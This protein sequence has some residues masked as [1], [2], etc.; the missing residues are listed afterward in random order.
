MAGNAAAVLQ[1]HHRRLLVIQSAVGT[2]MGTTWDRLANVDQPSAERFTKAAATL[3]TA[4]VAATAALSRSMYDVLAPEIDGDIAPVVIRGG[5]PPAELYQRSIITS[6]SLLAAGATWAAAMAAGRARAVSAARTDVMLANRAAAQAQ[7]DARP[8]VEGFTRLLDPGACEYCASLADE[9]YSSADAVPLHNNCVIGS[10]RVD[11]LDLREVSRRRYAGEVVVLRTAAGHELAITPNHPV[12]T[13][14]GWVAAG[15]LREGMDVIGRTAGDRVG[16]GVPH[17]HDV[18]ARIEDRFRAGLMSRLARMPFAT[19]HFH[20]D[21]GQGEVDVVPAHRHLGHGLFAKLDQPAEELALTF[22][23]LATPLPRASGALQDVLVLATTTHRGVRR[24]DLSEPLLRCHRCGH[25]R[26]RFSQTTRRDARPHKA[27]TD[28]R[29]RDAGF[30][31]DLQ[32]GGAGNVAPD[33]IV[34]LRRVGGLHD[35]FNLHTGNGWYWAESIAVHNCGCSV[36]PIIGRSDPARALNGKLL[37]SLKPGS[38]DV[39][40]HEHGEMGAVITDAA[41][42]FST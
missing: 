26:G 28:R 21:I 6:R 40:V 20:G 9:T 35:V 37:D 42:E 17:E 22:G 38:A 24:H 2:N 34:E 25:E 11:G 5:L 16:R 30:P 33:R 10:I 18:P 36:A 4:S 7:A 39:A 23:G 32:L 12:L 29:T 1:A 13:P 41:D 31:A 15:E 14:H 8:Q 27:A 19:E 3:S